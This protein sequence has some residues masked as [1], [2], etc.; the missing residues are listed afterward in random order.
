ME[1]AI[2]LA[3]C[4]ADVTLSYRKDEFNRPEAREP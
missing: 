3:K 2:A 4:G 1:A